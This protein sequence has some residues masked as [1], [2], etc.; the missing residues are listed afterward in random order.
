MV[1]LALFL[2]LSSGRLHT[3]N[4]ASSTSGNQ[5]SCAELCVVLIIGGKIRCGDETRVQMSFYAHNGCR[6]VSR[7]ARAD[8][9][10]PPASQPKIRWFYL[11]V[12][13]TLTIEKKTKAHRRMAMRGVERMMEYNAH[14]GLPSIWD[15][16]EHALMY[17]DMCYDIERFSCMYGFVM[18]TDSHIDLRIH[19][20]YMR[21]SLLVVILYIC[22]EV[23]HSTQIQRQNGRN[24]V[25]DS[26]ATFLFKHIRRPSST[27]NSKMSSHHNALRRFCRVAYRRVLR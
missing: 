14:I 15:G 6:F 16:F 13:Q 3:R 1:A 17:C 19:E 2:G 25:S 18:Y 12:R 23:A 20:L 26:Q 27:A 9:T 24:R 5:M 4:P 7:A 11:G 21:Q 8:Y 22:F 10:Q